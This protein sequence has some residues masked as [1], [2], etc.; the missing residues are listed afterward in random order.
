VPRRLIPAELAAY[1]DAWVAVTSP[2]PSPIVSFAARHGEAPWYLLEAVSKFLRR[3]P[4][5]DTGLNYWDRQMLENV[6]TH[7]PKAGNVLAHTIEAMFED[8]DLV[9]DLFMASRLLV[10]SNPELPK[11]LVNFTGS[12]LQVSRAEVTL[13]DFG[14][15]VLSGDESAFPANPI[16]DWAGG[17]HLSS[18]NGNLWFN[19]G[20]AIVRA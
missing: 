6:K 1:R 17:V 9:G 5:L 12:R 11:P 4:S 8:G 10:M 15:R 2:E 14:E 16:D 7:G 20:G 18:S 13:T 19:D 3:Y